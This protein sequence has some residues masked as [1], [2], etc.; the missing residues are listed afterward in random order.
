MKELDDLII[1]GHPPIPLNAKG[2]GT[3]TYNRNHKYAQFAAD[4]SAAFAKFYAFAF[5]LAKSAYVVLRGAL[6]Q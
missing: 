4:S 6:L 1:A 5:A 3:D 2:F